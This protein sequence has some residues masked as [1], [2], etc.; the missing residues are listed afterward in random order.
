MEL[1]A[2]NADSDKDIIR[3]Q[4]EWLKVLQSIPPKK[5][6]LIKAIEGKTP[7]GADHELYTWL[8]YANIWIKIKQPIYTRGILPNEILI[9]PDTPEWDVMKAGIEKLIEYCKKN[10]IPFITGFSGGKG[11]HVSI[12][13]NACR[14]DK[15]LENGIEETGIDVLKTARRALVKTLAEKAGVNLDDIRTDW[16]KIDFNFYNKGSQVRTFG[17]VRAPG[18][19][20]TLVDKIPDHKPEPYE[21]PLIFPEKVE[22]WEIENT[23]FK[24]VVLDALRKEV[25]RARKSNEYSLTDADFTGIEIMKFP[26]IKKLFE[27]GIKNGRYYAGL[28]VLLMCKKC[29]ISK[30]ETE[31]HMRELFKTFP[32]IAQDETELRINNALTMYETDKKFSCRG[33][34]DDFGEDFCNY[35]KCPV[36]NKVDESKK[37]RKESNY[38][39]LSNRAREVLNLAFKKMLSNDG[40]KSKLKNGEGFNKFDSE[41]VHEDMGGKKEIPDETLI[42]HAYRLKKYKKQLTEFGIDVAELDD[43]IKESTKKPKVEEPEKVTVHFDEVAEQILTENHIFS[44]RDNGQIYLYKDGAYRGEGTEAILGT[45]IRDTYSS[46]YADRWQEVNSDFDLPEHTPKATVRYVNEAI[47]Y[48][49]AYTHIPREDIEIFQEKYINFK[50]RLFNLDTWEFEDHTPEIKT[51]CQIPVSYDEAA[52]CPQ[53]TGFLQDVAKHEDINFLEEWAGYCLTNDVSYQKALMLYGSPGTGKSVFASMLEAFIGD[54]NSASESLQKIEEDKYR[55]A[56]LYGK[57]VN[58]CS[59]IPSTKM[60]K[61]EVFKKLVSGLDSIDAENKFKDPFKFKNKAKLTFSANKIP[62]GPKDPA[63]YERFCLIEFENKFR[64]TDKDDKKLI[65]KLTTDSELSG[66]LNVALKGLKRLYENERFSY[67]KTFE[68]TER[69]Y[70]LNSNPVAFFMEERTVISNDDID[71]T[72]L[73]VS[74]VDW[75]ITNNKQHVSKIEFSRQLN[76]MGYTNHRENVK[77]DGS[78]KV[79][80]WD[81]LQLKQSEKV[82]K[83]GTDEDEKEDFGQDLRQDRENRSCPKNSSLPLTESFSKNDFG[84]DPI[85]FAGFVTQKQKCV[86]KEIETVKTPLNGVEENTPNKV[87]TSCPSVRFF[88]NGEYGQDLLNDPVLDP[89]R[90]QKTLISDQQ[91]DEDFIKKIDYLQLFRRDIKNLVSSD[92]NGIVESI[93]ELLEIFNKRNPGYKQALGYQTLLEEANK[94]NEWGWN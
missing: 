27:S 50:N 82:D 54:E 44:M 55:A 15:E 61:T 71:S 85:S 65:Q 21:L 58:I 41:A 52:E 32:G 8:P 66:F 68:E 86:Y 91:Q 70:I 19:Y 10:N 87:K 31:K 23:E 48:I 26:C 59:D 33:L 79:T 6:I 69:E 78:K 80:L 28:S 11:I 24:D 90:E 36:K 43:V 62:E 34:K 76:K 93:P 2:V 1:P 72:V 88:D 57:R 40:D 63:F 13:F 12:F 81:N 83:D 60:H 3:A 74:Y 30:E 20:K 67:N 51:I 35:T 7:K 39:Q 25:S 45:Q 16:G 49:L 37:K 18:Q 14:V 64:G 5:M 47:A 53:I 9:D 42:K 17:T 56:R 4:K 94:I 46:M 29:G 84:Q 77:K 73:Y 22:L 38:V 89:V 92:Y 75:S